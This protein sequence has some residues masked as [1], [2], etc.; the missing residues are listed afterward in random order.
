M[1]PEY[2]IC[3]ATFVKRFKTY[4]K[5]LLTSIKAM[6][7][8]A[9]IIVVVNGEHNQLFDQEYRRDMLNFLS[10][11]DNVYPIILT[12]HRSCSKLWNTALLNATNDLCLRIDDDVTIPND[13]FFNLLDQVI[14]QTNSKSFKINGSWSH[15]LLNRREIDS[16]GWFDERFLGGGEE[17]GDFE[18]RWADRYGEEFLNIQGLPI[19]NHWDQMD[20]DDCLVGHR[21]V[22]GKRSMFNLEFVNRKYMEHPNGKAYGIMCEN[23]NKKVICVDPT[24][25]QYPNESF[26]WQ[27]R[28]KL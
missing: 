10:E 6:R 15:T 25:N 8:E 12:Q 7:P 13:S 23:G 19:S 27:N 14:L 2:S 26:Y 21:K 18:W 5:P 4:F 20:F 24:L 9:E 1:I 16:V 28:S 11:F 17:D 22:N 3:I